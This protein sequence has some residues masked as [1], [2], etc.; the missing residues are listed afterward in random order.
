MIWQY[1][2]LTAFI[3][4]SYV[5]GTWIT[6]VLFGRIRGVFALWSSVLTGF[7]VSVWVA[8]CIASLTGNISIAVVTFAVLGLV[9]LFLFRK[10]I[11]PLNVIPQSPTEWIVV[12]G[13]LSISTWMMTKT[14]HTGSD[15][16]ILVGANE[17]FDFGHAISVIRS[18]SQG[19]NLPY[20]SP[21][22]AGT[23]HVYHFLFYFWVAI[24]ERFGIPIAWAFNIP[25]ILAMTGLLCVI[26]EITT[27]LF[28]N[29]RAG[30]FAV[31]FTLMHS[32]LMFWYFLTDPMKSG[33]LLTNIWRNATYYFAGPF[34]GSPISIFWT[35]NVFVNQRHIVF[36]LAS[37]LLLA[38]AAWRKKDA[39]GSFVLFV[40]VAAGML[41]WW[42]TMLSLAAIFVITLFYIL[43]K[44]PKRA[45]LFAGVAAATLALGVSPWLGNVA[46]S[47]SQT[48]PHSLFSW[49]VSPDLFT[50]LRYWFLNLG[51]ALATIPLGYALLPKEKKRFVW[52][53]IMLFLL[54]NFF[55]VGRDITENHKFIN[56]VLIVG[57]MLSAGCVVWLFGKKGFVQKIG[58][59]LCVILLAISGVLDMMVIKN[60]FQYP[61]LDYATSP[62]MR[63]VRDDTPKNAVFLSY[64]DIFDPVA[65]AGRKTYAGFFGAAA[66]PDR[67]AT[68]RTIYEATDSAGIEL[69]GKE[70]IDYIVV[71]KWKKDDFP[72]V[73]D[74]ERMRSLYPVSY[75][76]DRH[77]VFNN[78]SILIE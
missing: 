75:E 20:S 64:Q 65:L 46:A 8:Y 10:K 63:W 4:L 26:Y 43:G 1:A 33:N 52:P 54:A 23:A 25:S 48:G 77:I 2:V 17:V 55:R 9:L 38:Y 74:V 5:Q 68:V 27:Y 58:A 3:L 70:G 67:M 30:L 32:T 62:F 6:S 49:F 50:F 36:G 19:D 40:G 34:D 69:A 78:R 39:N 18:F 41:L 60:D 31:F 73:V 24:F 56:L 28:K 16:S 59:A 44:Q 53:F 71:P 61:V 15:G 47:R 72:Y 37:V 12:V 57:N 11:Q 76:D 42:H 7:F 29:S 51:L 66:V 21:F 14:F 35:L 13:S 45:V 22:I